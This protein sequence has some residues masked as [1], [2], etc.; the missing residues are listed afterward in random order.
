M[1][2]TKLGHSCLLVE[3]PERTA[4]FDPGVWSEVDVDSLQYL[5]DIIITHGHGDH[6]EV[7][8]IKAMQAKFPNA[9]ISGE[10]SALQALSDQGV[11]VS[12]GIAEG[13]E[14]FEAPH[15]PTE[16]LAPTPDNV[17][18]HYLD[19]LTV[20][21]DCIHF[22]ETKAI[23]A[24]PLTAPWGATVDCVSLALKLK[25]QYVLPV[26]DALWHKEI[27]EYMYDLVGKALEKEGITFIPLE[28]GKPVNIGV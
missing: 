25:P 15:E 2:I 20:S 4:L 18:I 11:S 12:Q 26:H 21:G 14:L 10:S 19:T 13:V 8:T 5:D 27:R 1:K 16:P 3:M 6:M 17:G 23:L 22:E 7:N 9:R 24:L 28:N